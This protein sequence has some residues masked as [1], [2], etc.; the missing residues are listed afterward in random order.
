M[1]C[2]TIQTDRL[3]I[4][5]YKEFD[6]DMQYQFLPDER[7]HQFISPPKLS[8]EEELEVIK[9]WIA[10]SDTDHYERWMILHK[11]NHEPIGNISVNRIGRKNNDCNVGYPYRNSGC[12]HC[13]NCGLLVFLIWRWYNMKRKI[14]MDSER[15]KGSPA[16]PCARSLHRLFCRIVNAGKPQTQGFILM[17]RTK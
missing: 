1:H 4:R 2:P 9:K 5:R 11:N 6:I 7:L 15:V 3:I 12:I 10:N 8:R 13:S 16:F 14:S 17:N